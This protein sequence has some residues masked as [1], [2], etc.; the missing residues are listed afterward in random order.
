[1]YHILLTVGTCWVLHSVF[2]NIFLSIRLQH[3]LKPQVSSAAVRPKE[4]DS[5]FSVAPIVCGFSY[6]HDCLWRLCV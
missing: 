1:M 2:M 3:Q 5:L 6:C 4:V